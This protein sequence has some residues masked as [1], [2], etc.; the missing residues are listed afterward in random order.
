MSTING[1]FL[2]AFSG[3]APCSVSGRVGMGLTQAQCQTRG[4]SPRKPHRTN[5]LKHRNLTL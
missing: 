2:L 1:R 4:A 3:G 5:P